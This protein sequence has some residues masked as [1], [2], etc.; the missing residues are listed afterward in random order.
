MEFHTRKAIYQ[1]I[2]DFLC[3]RIISGE[4]PEESRLPSVRD[5]ALTLSVNPNT[6]MRT[7]LEMERHGILSNQRGVGLFV[8]KEGKEK[9]RALMREEFESHDLPALVAAMT[10][11]DIDADG[12]NAL[13]RKHIRKIR[14][15]P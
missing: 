14:G 15:N 13:I 6:V 3:G 7:C 2:G 9:A 5:L 12:L 8:A 10:M 11:L 1:Q 4:W